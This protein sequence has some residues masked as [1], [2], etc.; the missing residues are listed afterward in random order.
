M[1]GQTLAPAFVGVT[2]PLLVAARRAGD[3][4]LKRVS[5]L[6][7]RFAL[8]A[9]G[10]VC[11]ILVIA[12]PWLTDWMAP[13]FRP[14]ESARA[15]SQVRWLSLVFLA[16]GLSF[17][18][19]ARLNLHGVFWP[20]A[21]TSLTLSLGI[22][23]VCGL[24]WRVDGT[25]TGLVM[26]S[27]LAAWC[28]LAF[29]AAAVRRAGRVDPISSESLS[30]VDGEAVPLRMRA[31]SLAVLGASLYQL[32][33]AVPRFLD[34]GYAS[35]EPG[36]LAALEYS[37]N[38]LTAPGILFGT[39][40]VMLAFPR[41]ARFAARGEARAGFRALG[42]WFG[43]AVG[44][45]GVVTLACQIA[46]EALVRLLYERGEFGADD[47]SMTSEILRWQAWGL[48][49][50]VASM[51]LAQALLGLRQLRLLL[52]V[53]VVRIVVRVLALQVLVPE[54]GPAGLGA[55]YFATEAVSMLLLVIILWRVTHSSAPPASPPPAHGPARD[56]AS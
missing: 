31:L 54:F 55:A 5:A 8:I 44:A 2:L 33:Q 28:V 53:G 52:L 26:A 43:L 25:T 50:M 48:P 20:G 3:A 1:L 27:V 19:R 47:V 37:F 38:V 16:L 9:T 49:A 41:F 29:H 24:G 32:T 21:S 56:P 15:A 30:E 6:L 14:E 39:S 34:R 46:P 35:Q 12:A 13:G 10:S 17:P 18:L 40:L 7:T 4:E 45:A 42:K 51:G 23:L 11:L 36:A 22:V